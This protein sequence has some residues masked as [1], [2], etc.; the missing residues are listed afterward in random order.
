MGAGAHGGAERAPRP[1]AGKTTSAAAVGPRAG[2]P[3]RAAASAAGATA[4]AGQCLLLGRLRSGFYLSLRA[5]C[6]CVCV[7]AV[8]VCCLCLSCVSVCVSV[9]C[10]SLSS[11][12]LCLS[13]SHP[14]SLSPSLSLTLS[15]SLSPSLSLS[16]SLSLSSKRLSL[17]SFPLS[18]LPFISPQSVLSLSLNPPYSPLSPLS[19]HPPSLC[20]PPSPSLFS[21]SLCP[22]P[23]LSPLPP[24]LSMC[25]DS[26]E[27]EV[28]V[29]E[30]SS[31]QSIF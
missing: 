20:L 2:H 6:V 28:R 4:T 21:L 1:T 5:F 13:V 31:P 11:L 7:C 23:P 3:S 14:L 8:S 25:I 27:R 18:P 22:P 30:S 16:V 10:L 26:L 12:G 15:L 24:L 9:C 29:H 17:M 19:K